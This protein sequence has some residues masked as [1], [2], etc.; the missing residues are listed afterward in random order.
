MHSQCCPRHLHSIQT[1]PGVQQANQPCG[2]VGGRSGGRSKLS[3]CLTNRDTFLGLL[4]Y[5]WYF[6]SHLLLSQ[7]PVFGLENIINHLA[8]FSKKAP[9]CSAVPPKPQNADPKRLNQT[10]SVNNAM[11]L[12]GQNKYMYI[13]VCLTKAKQLRSVLLSHRMK[14]YIIN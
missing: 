1:A 8:S 2:L 4:L 7:S 5:F 6:G 13:L 12:P 14:Q 11:S 9:N 3:V 10:N